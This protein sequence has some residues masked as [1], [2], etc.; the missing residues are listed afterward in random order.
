M[1]SDGAGSKH[2]IPKRSSSFHLKCIFWIENDPFLRALL[3]TN[4]ERKRVRL[5]FVIDAECFRHSGFVAFHWTKINPTLINVML[6]CVEE[7]FWQ[8][9]ISS[10]KDKLQR[11]P[12]DKCIHTRLNLFY[13]FLFVWRVSIWI[14]YFKWFGVQEW[15]T[16]QKGGFDGWVGGGRKVGGSQKVEQR[17]PAHIPMFLGKICN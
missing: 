13:A 4:G 3:Y 6:F 8:T 15:R 7:Y 16:S 9:N 2:R 11:W 17:A 1:F 10:D 12:P 14:R 5:R